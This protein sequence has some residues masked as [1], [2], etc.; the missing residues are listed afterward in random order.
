M[1]SGP[2]LSSGLTTAA[3][4]AAAAAAA[5]TLVHEWWAGPGAH[6]NAESF[7]E[8]YLARAANAS[9]VEHPAISGCLVKPADR[10]EA[11]EP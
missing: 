7:L 9:I 1:L 11:G 8:A 6:W 3:A 2:N 4:A 5:Q 10:D